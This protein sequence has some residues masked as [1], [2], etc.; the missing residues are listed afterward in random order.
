MMEGN[1][2]NKDD[3]ADPP[4]TPEHLKNLVDAATTDKDFRGLFKSLAQM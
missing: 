4:L 2:A 1:H 3:S